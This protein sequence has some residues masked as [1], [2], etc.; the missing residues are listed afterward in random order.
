MLALNDAN[1]LSCV[2]TT[3]NEAF[4]DAAAVFSGTVIKANS[5]SYTI[6][7]EDVYKGNVTETVKVKGSEWDRGFKVNQMLLIYTD[8]TA[9]GHY[10]LDLCSRTGSFKNLEYDVQGMTP[11]KPESDPFLKAPIW[12]G[13]ISIGAVTAVV[14]FRKK[15][16]KH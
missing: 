14:F 11:A 4:D 7:V 2:E 1:A 9:L 13:I 12:A 10:K 8:Q 6:D 16:Q 3:A 15:G 5:H